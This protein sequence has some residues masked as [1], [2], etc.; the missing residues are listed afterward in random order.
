MAD[1]TRPFELPRATRPPSHAAVYFPG[2]TIGNFSPAE[3]HTMLV[4]IRRIL[5]PLGGL[6][7]GID[8][9]KD[10]ETIEAAYNASRQVTDEF[11]SN[12]LR[13]ANRELGADFDLDRFSL[14]AVYDEELGRVELSMV[15]DTD[16]TVTIADRRFDF[17]AGERVRIEYSHK[18]TIEGFARM[19]QEAG[20][21][22]HRHWTDPDDMFAVLHL[23]NEG[24]QP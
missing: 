10:P 14:E 1:F 24:G 2:S 3:V 9:R 11:I 18:Y 4:R 20:F 6:L 8:L 5:G 23:V 22:L 12:L 7:I 19:A 16:Q 15:S 13:R 21:S 17:A